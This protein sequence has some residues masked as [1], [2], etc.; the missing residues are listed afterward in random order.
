MSDTQVTISNKT[1]SAEITIDDLENPAPRIVVSNSEKEYEHILNLG[2]VNDIVSISYSL[3]SQIQDLINKSRRSAHHPFAMEEGQ[4]FLKPLKAIENPDYVVNDCTEVVALVPQNTTDMTFDG[5]PVLE[6]GVK[7][8]NNSRGGRFGI[9]TLSDEDLN[10]EHGWRL[11]LTGAEKTTISFASWNN[12]EAILGLIQQAQDPES[13]L[14]V[15][16]MTD[17]ETTSRLTSRLNAREILEERAIKRITLKPLK[18]IMTDN[19][20]ATSEDNSRDKRALL[21]VLS[22]KFGKKNLPVACV[23]LAPTST[24]MEKEWEAYKN[25]HHSDLDPK[26]TTNRPELYRL[27]NEFMEEARKNW[28]KRLTQVIESNQEWRVL[29]LPAPDLGWRFRGREYLW[30]TPLNEETW[31]VVQKAAEVEAP[32]TSMGRGSSF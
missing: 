4:Q 19:G 10:L 18:K 32:K 16:G 5:I 25:I 23:V 14:I 13:L 3:G 8:T 6:W 12:P 9:R 30:V 29:D 21:R 2:E 28:I 15:S 1:V 11:Y 20:F 26:N 7:N 22:I 17:P 27:R 24:E 31:S